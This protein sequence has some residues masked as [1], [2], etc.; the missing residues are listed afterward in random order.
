MM[1]LRTVGLRDQLAFMQMWWPAFC[2]R[3]RNG[4]LISEGDLVPN[5]LC[6]T[7][8]VRITLPGGGVPAVRVIS[9]E[10]RPREK[11]GRIPHMYEQETTMP[12]LARHW[13]MDSGEACRRDDRALDLGVA[14][15]LRS[16]ARDRGVAGR[17]DRT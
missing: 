1:R 13:R 12:V 6:A 11:G 4:V 14:V 9:P 7:Y 17:R 16:V 10:L 5:E 15:L 8:R 3:V 2:S